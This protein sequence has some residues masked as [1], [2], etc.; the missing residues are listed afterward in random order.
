MIFSE[1]EHGFKLSAEDPEGNFAVVP[2][3]RDK[4]LAKKPEQSHKTLERQLKRL[5]ESEFTC[6][7]L[8]I[9]LSQHYFLPISQIN[10]L[11]REIVEAIRAERGRNF[12]RWTTEIQ[13]I[14]FPYPAG[15]KNS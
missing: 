1:A 11:R 10:S 7:D 15:V 13:P 9:N 2:I 3:I 4:V 6:D 12:P 8:E 5:G 14:D